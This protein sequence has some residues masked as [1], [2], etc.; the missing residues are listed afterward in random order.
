MEKENEEVA[1]KNDT[2]VNETDNSKQTAEQIDDVPTV[3]DYN[4]L[5]QEKEELENKN[6]QL[7]ARVKKSEPLK[8]NNADSSKVED[9]ELR[10]EL[11][12]RDIPLDAMP[13]VKA[14]GGLKGLDNPYV[15]SAIEAI[16]TQKN[17][18][19]ATEINSSQKSA[20]E[21]QYTHAEL[22]AMKTEDLEK[23]LPH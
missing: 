8:I 18:E 14:N 21:K 4:R 22:R 17:A 9:L 2:T 23:L 10:I 5:K 12:D 1:S 15:K 19:K 16:K 20:I 11:R 7:Y 3:D 13:F 6:K